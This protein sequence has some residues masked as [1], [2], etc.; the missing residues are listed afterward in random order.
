VP[1]RL[2]DLKPK[3]EK[4]DEKKADEKKTDEKKAD[5]KDD[6]RDDE[7]EDEKKEDEKKGTEKEDEKEED[8]KKADEKK[9]DEKKDEKKGKKDKKQKV[10]LVETTTKAWRNS[11]SKHQP[12][13]TTLSHCW[14]GK[15]ILRLRP[16]NHSELLEQGVALDDLPLTFKHAVDF[17][18]RLNVRYIWIDSLC[19]KQGGSPEA[20]EDWLH[21]SAS[22]DK[23]YGC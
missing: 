10:Y 23:V 22:M 3:D 14:G 21:Q 7:R 6:K 5:E 18:Q 19:I 17:T 4:D 16:E 20:T 1:G 15:D 11:Y 2:L 9:A 13:Y 8:E 12:R